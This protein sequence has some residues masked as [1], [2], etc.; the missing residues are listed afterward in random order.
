M[1]TTNNDFKFD[2]SIEENNY[3]RLLKSIANE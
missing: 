3:I 2:S 1:I